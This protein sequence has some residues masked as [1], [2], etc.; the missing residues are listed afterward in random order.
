[1]FMGSFSMIT[2]ELNRYITELGG[3]EYKGLIFLLYGLGALM[4]RPISGRLTDTVGR[5]SVMVIGSVIGIIAGILYPLTGYL[6]AFLFL[7]YFHGFSSGFKPIG[8]T[9]YL[10]D[11]VHKDFR[12][13]ALGYLGMAGS[14]GMAAGP[15][16]GSFIATNFSTNAMF[17]TSSCLA[18]VSLITV[19]GMK[20]S[21]QN[22]QK[23]SPK[24]LKISMKD[25]YSKR[26]WLP[27]LMMMFSIFSFGTIL[28]IIPD[29][30]DF[31]GIKNRGTF[32]LFM[33][34]SSI[35]TRFFAGKMS[36][37]YGRKKTLRVGLLILSIGMLA[38]GFAFD[39]WSLAAAACIC[40]VSVGINS[41]TIFAWTIDLAPDDERGPAVSTMLSALEV[42][43]IVSSLAASLLYSNDS[44]MFPYTF[45]LAG[46]IAFIAFVILIFVK[47][48]PIEK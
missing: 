22:R 13:E 44:S 23:F 38:T 20:E 16:V 14:T 3:A 27:S 7:R 29:F 5:I 6:T 43:I 4:I 26:V 11:I 41:P 17:I 33:V 37:K 28:V 24:L 8:T 9:A 34:L 35:G 46:C 21:L 2:P 12:G 39:Y 32:M 36:D 15:Y 31:L 42:G 10:A 25:V 48:T 19:L 45:W 18:V 1:M 40:G 47:E 30:H